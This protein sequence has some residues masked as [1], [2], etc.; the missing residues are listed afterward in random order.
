M[1]AVC[2][3]AAV[4]KRPDQKQRGEERAYALR[5]QSITEGRSQGRE[6]RRTQGEVLPPSS[7]R[8]SGLASYLIQPR[9][10]CPEV[11]PPT[12][13]PP[14]GSCQ[15]KKFVT[16]MSTDQPDRGR[17][18]EVLPSAHVALGSVKLTL[19]SLC[20]EALFRRKLSLKP[21]LV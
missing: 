9:A 20:Y 5:S 10:T 21:D 18:S 15:V 19:F 3:A 11:V 7:L 2:F 4:I 17:S 14:V 1:E 8:G 16:D 13:G 12:V 6:S